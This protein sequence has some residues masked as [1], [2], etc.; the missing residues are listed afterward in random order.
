MGIYDREYYSE[1]DQPRGIQLGG[2]RMIVTNLVIVNVIIFLIDLLFKIRI[3]GVEVHPLSY[4]FKLHADLLV[5]PWRFYQLL[6]AGFLHS[7]RS[8]T[9]VLFNMLGLWIFGREI[10]IKYGRK[11]FLQFY[12]SSIVLSNLIW[13]LW[14]VALAGSLTPNASAVGA[15]GGVFAV[16]TVFVLNYP[17]RTIYIWAVIPVPAWTLGAI[18]AVF[19]F[20][21]PDPEVAHAAHVGGVLCGLLFFYRSWQLGK[22]IPSGFS[23]AQLR[24]RSRLR[25][26]DPDR[27]DR[28]A[29]AKMSDE[30]DR[31]LEKISREGESSLTSRERRTL[32][33][34]SRKYQQR[35][36]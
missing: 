31:I 16:L 13:V 32:E 8:L 35:R 19:T 23:L 29:A 22:L 26:H 1:Y 9:H 12:L 17:H 7:T 6:T 11:I 28:E 18:F 15:S 24:P 27:K 30:V 2:S 14:E 34:A 25:I 3:D 20:L 5:Q 4:Y 33:D 21:L 10:E 36:R